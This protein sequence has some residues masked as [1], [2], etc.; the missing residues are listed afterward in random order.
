MKRLIFLGVVVFLA[1]MLATFP[2]KVAY[3]WGSPAEFRLSGITGSI[4]NGGA[5]A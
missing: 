1:V 2:A 3:D 5:A 4:W